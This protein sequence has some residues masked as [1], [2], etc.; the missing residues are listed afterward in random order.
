MPFKENLVRWKITSDMSCTHCKG[1]ET[2]AHALL[3]C[4]E[5]NLFWKNV[6]FFICTQFKVNMTIDEKLLFTGFE[7][8]DKDMIIPNIILTFAQYTI[9]RVNMLSKFTSKQFNSFSLVTELK[10]ILI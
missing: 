8:E 5:V 4:P 7:I 3:Y 10:K 6:K 1:I 9:Y 2:I